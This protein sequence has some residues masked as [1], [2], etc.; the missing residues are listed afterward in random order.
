MALFF[1]K[2]LESGATIS[3]W[4]IVE[5]EKELLSLSSIPSDELEELSLI[6]SSDRRREKLA[7][8][9]LLNQLFGEKVYLGHHDNGRPFLQ[10]S[11]TEISISHTKRFVAIITHPE[12]SVGIDIESL[13]RDFTAVEKKALSEEEID[14]LSDKNRQLHLAI[15][16]CAKEAIYK[17]MSI[18]DVD[19]SNQIEIKRFTPRDNG[20][21]KAT[22]IK[23]DGEE[24]EFDLEYMVFENH[25]MVWLVG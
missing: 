16:W 8:R 12:E 23:S 3:V 19:F 7:V 5:S 15:Y 20:D 9:A 13:D 24:I 1:S 25:V 6:K 4:E 21:I 10:N 2:K 14:D 22:F 18:S 17:R 11:L